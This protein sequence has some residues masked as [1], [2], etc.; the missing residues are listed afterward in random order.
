MTISLQL[1]KDK[2]TLI[3][4]LNRETMPTTRMMK[5]QMSTSLKAVLDAIPS[6][7]ASQNQRLLNIIHRLGGKPLQLP[8]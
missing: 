5:T 8:S 1:L 4:F 2:S 6:Q 7:Q 3:P